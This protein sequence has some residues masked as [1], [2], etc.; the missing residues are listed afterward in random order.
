VIKGAFA[1]FLCLFLSFHVCKVE[2]FKSVI[3]GAFV[4]TL[5]KVFFFKHNLVTNSKVVS[6]SSFCKLKVVLTLND[7]MKSYLK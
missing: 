6:N 4:L 5:K 7:F 2:K 3:K 1:R